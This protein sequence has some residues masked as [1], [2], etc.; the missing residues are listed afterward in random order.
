MVPAAPLYHRVGRGNGP[1]SLLSNTQKCLWNLEQLS[2]FI[3]HPS[4]KHTWPKGTKRNISHL[5]WQP[6]QASLILQESREHATPQAPVLPTEWKWM[7]EHH[8]SCCNPTYASPSHYQNRMLQFL[9]GL[10]PAR[11]LDTQWWCSEDKYFR[12]L[13]PLDSTLSCVLHSSKSNSISVRGYPIR[14]TIPWTARVAPFSGGPERQWIPSILIL[15]VLS[16][17]FSIMDE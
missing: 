12:S 1:F 4:S 10:L 11:S 3:R 13:P 17:N 14:A 6:S 9:P 15:Y 5:H 7:H 16:P 2:H 8:H